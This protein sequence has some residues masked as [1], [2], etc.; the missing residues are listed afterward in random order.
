MGSVPG[1]VYVLF[2]LDRVLPGAILSE[3]GQ[4]K[5]GLLNYCA[6]FPIKV[7]V[8]SFGKPEVLAASSCGT[9][10]LERAGLWQDSGLCS[11]VLQVVNV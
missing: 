3:V 10:V 8:A 4:V 7:V 11:D 1:G 2:G 6:L 9:K 5:K